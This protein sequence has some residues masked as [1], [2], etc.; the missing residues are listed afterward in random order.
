MKFWAC[1]LATLWLAFPA[2]AHVLEANTAR[3][4]WRDQHLEVAAELDVLALMQAA[5]PGHPDATALAVATDEDLAARVQATRQTLIEETRLQVDGHA[6]QLVL[7]AFPTATEVRFLAALH[8]SQ[9]DG[10]PGLSSIRLEVPSP[11]VEARRVSLQMAPAAGRVLCTFVQPVT[12]VASPGA[13]VEFAVLRAPQPAPTSDPQL[14]LAVGGAG[15]CVGF[16]LA[17]LVRRGRVN[18]PG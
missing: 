16:L 8:S 12:Q 6:Q 2:E 14:W 10:H 11:V 3:L 17:V 15:V 5:L 13:P 18:R 9:P 1:L 7:T 4:T